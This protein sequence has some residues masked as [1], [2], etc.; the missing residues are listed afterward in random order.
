MVEIRA[1]YDKFIVPMIEKHKQLFDANVHTFELYK[2]MGSLI[3]AYSFSTEE[4]V[5]MMPMAGK[6]YECQKVSLLT[7][8]QTC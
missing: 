1:D 5:A 4:E 8:P 3:M 7:P 6:T 2:R